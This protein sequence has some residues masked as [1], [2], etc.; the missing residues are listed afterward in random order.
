VKRD[1]LLFS[2]FSPDK[3]GFPV[4]Y[5]KKYYITKSFPNLYLRILPKPF[6][7]ARTRKHSGGTAISPPPAGT[8]VLHACSDKFRGDGSKNVY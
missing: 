4:V 5:S 2:L 8:V 6:L 3:L 7:R 1:V